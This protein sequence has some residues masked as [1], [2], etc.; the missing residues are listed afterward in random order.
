M[1]RKGEAGVTLIELAVV[2]AIVAIIALFMAPALGEW[3][4]NFRIRQ[5]ARDIVST[6]QLAK[7][8]TISTRT[9]HTVTF[10]TA[11]ETLQILPGGSVT[12]VSRGVNIDSTDF[13]GNAIQFNP[14]GTTSSASIDDSIFIN[15]AKGKQYRIRITPSGSIRMQEGW[16]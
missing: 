13:P 6:L 4:D 3:V 1:M 16:S 9:Q 7:M 15:N 12:K 11:A 14:N 5:T 8:Q 10:D 2:M